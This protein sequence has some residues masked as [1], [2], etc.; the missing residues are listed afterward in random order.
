MSFLSWLGVY[1]IIKGIVVIGKSAVIV[2]IYVYFI[3]GSVDEVGILG[4][5]PWI[6]PQII[7]WSCTN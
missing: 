6:W 2:I 1:V 3:V 5:L 7:R 4:R